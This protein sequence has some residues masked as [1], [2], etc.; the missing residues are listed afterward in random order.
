MF[1]SI[2]KNS[3]LVVL[4]SILVAGITLKAEDAAPAVDTAPAVT[5]APA[6]PTA[7][8]PY[9]G[10][11]V[12]VDKSMSSFTVEIKGQ[13][14]LFKVSPNTVFSRKGKPIQLKDL[15][16][17]QEITLVIQQAAS[18]VIEVVSV[19]INPGQQALESA[20]NG[21]GSSNNSNGNSKKKLDIGA[22]PYGGGG[23]VVSPYN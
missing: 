14:Y 11:I 4:S 10:K 18:G 5:S 9:S 15:V 2:C 8:T 13:L 22:P 21:N 23:P 19:A 1:K 20:G 17:G 6:G 7:P 12:V 3:W 16:P